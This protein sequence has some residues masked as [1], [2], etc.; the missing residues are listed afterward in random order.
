MSIVSIGFGWSSATTLLISASFD[1]DDDEAR[2]I[3]LGALYGAALAVVDM[4]PSGA[5]VN[6]DIHPDRA[7]PSRDRVR[8]TLCPRDES[9]PSRGPGI[10]RHR[11]AA[12]QL[13]DEYY[14]R[15]SLAMR[16]QRWGSQ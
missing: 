1:R 12:H 14:S 13:A 11:V 15:I 5:G 7:K 2:A 8:L 16:V 3:V 10:R 6:W 9:L 4:T